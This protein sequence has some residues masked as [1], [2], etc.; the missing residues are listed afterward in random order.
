MSYVPTSNFCVKSLNLNNKVKKFKN[1]QLIITT[2]NR[3]AF[4][5]TWKRFNTLYSLYTFYE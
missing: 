2:Q 1:P 4:Q 3:D 5:K